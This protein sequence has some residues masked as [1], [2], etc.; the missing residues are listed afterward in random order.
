MSISNKQIGRDINAKPGRISNLSKRNRAIKQC[1]PS[2]AKNAMHSVH[3]K[4][5]INSEIIE[6]C[7][8]LF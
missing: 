6:I 5:L 7:D 1:L 3:K 2:V 8:D 4:E